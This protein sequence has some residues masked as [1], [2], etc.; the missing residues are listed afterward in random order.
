MHLAQRRLRRVTIEAHDVCL[1]AKYRGMKV[2]EARKPRQLRDAKT[3]PRELVADLSLDKE[4][5]QLVIR[6]NGRA[7]PSADING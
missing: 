4:A 7:A 2:S 5:L 1:K 6:K 3:R